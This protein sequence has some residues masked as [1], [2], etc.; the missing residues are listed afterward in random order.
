MARR[1]LLCKEPF[2]HSITILIDIQY[3]IDRGLCQRL[4][5]AALGKAF[6]TDAVE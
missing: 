3:N 2:T 4:S 5:F 6:H 1:H